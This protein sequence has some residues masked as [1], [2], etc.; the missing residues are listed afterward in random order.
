MYQDLIVGLFFVGFIDSIFRRWGAHGE[1]LV[2]PL[3]I[4]WGNCVG[5][6]SFRH[7]ITGVDGRCQVI[8]FSE[9]C[10]RV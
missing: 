7:I 2:F 5:G 4:H 6:I 3:Y 10:V 1:T 9:N 8:S